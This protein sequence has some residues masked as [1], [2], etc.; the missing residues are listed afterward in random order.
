[1]ESELELLF[2]N[3][4]TG[5]Y[6][7][8]P[9]PCKSKP[10]K[11]EVRHGGKIVYFG[12]FATAEEAALSVARSP[13]GQASYNHRRSPPVLPQ[14]HRREMLDVCAADVCMV[15]EATPRPEG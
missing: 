9:Q 7:V 8:Y 4:K 2:S 14:Q 10:Y 12:S 6:G 11:A 13:E 1:M 3:N 15:E 5:F